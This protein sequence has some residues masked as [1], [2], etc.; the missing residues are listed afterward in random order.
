MPVTEED[1]RNARSEDES[2]GL[3]VQLVKDF[4]TLRSELQKKDETIKDHAEKLRKAQQRIAE[5]SEQL[6]AAPLTHG[7]EGEGDLSRFLDDDGKIRLMVDE[8]RRDRGEDSPAGLLDSEA[9]CEWQ[10]ALQKA[11]EQRTLV[12]VVKQAGDAA[13][14]WVPG[15]DNRI[16]TPILDARIQRLLKTAPRPIASAMR[17]MG[18]NSSQGGDWIVPPTLNRV[19]DEIHVRTS[20]AGLFPVVNLDNGGLD[21]PT[22]EG[23]LVPFRRGV[24]AGALPGNTP[25]TTL[26]TGKDQIRPEDLAIATAFHERASE[27]SIIGF[28]DMISTKGGRALGYALADAIINANGPDT[29]AIDN[30]APGGAHWDPRSIFGYAEPEGYPV[31]ID[32][33][34]GIYEGLRNRAKRVDAGAHWVDASTFSLD[35][36]QTAI[37][38]LEGPLGGNGELVLTTSREAFFKHVSTLDQLQTVDKYGDM[39]TVHEREV[40]Q[41]AGARVVIDDFLTADLNATGVYDGATKTT[42]SMQLFNRSEWTLHLENGVRIQT[43]IEILNG[44]IYV[45]MTWSGTLHCHAPTNR[46]NV[47]NFFKMAA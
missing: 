39:A 19:R 43:K 25:L 33:R 30:Y 22:V 9:S 45:V 26:K 6:T 46:K 31:A 15:G 8:S 38:N 2:R 23:G 47:V 20:I 44:L 21:I 11:F 28:Y 7:A 18:D 5:L 42:T 17:A 14:R 34:N 4:G 16:R 13:L 40:G 32:R 10:R 27:R 41:V 35:L 12:R 24:A 29:A 36:L 37:G 3:V 1:I